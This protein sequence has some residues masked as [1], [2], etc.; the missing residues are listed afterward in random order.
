M[1][2]ASPATSSFT[3]ASPAPATAAGS[4]KSAGTR[5]GTGSDADAQRVIAK[6]AETDRKVRAHEAAHLA[7]AGG[8]AHGGAH[9]TYQRGPDG[10]LYATGGDVSIDASSGRTP[11]DTLSRAERIRAAALAPADPSAQDYK[12]AAEASSMAAE[13]QLELSQQSAGGSA[14][15]N[16]TG[17]RQDASAVD[18]AYARAGSALGQRVDTSA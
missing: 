5:S 12:V 7:A 16:T 1:I 8:L 3:F 2:V 14:N 6:L 18:N 9:F 15:G 17:T 10:K 11:Q 13:A 4:G